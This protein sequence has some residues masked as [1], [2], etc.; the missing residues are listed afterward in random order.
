MRA[1]R[2]IAGNAG[3]ADNCGKCGQCGQCSNEH[4]AKATITLKRKMTEDRPKSLAT[5]QARPAYCDS[6]KCLKPRTGGPG[7]PGPICR[8]E[9][10][11]LFGDLDDLQSRYE[12]AE[13]MVNE[14]QKQEEALQ[15]QINTV[16]ERKVHTHTHKHT[17]THTDTHTLQVAMRHIMQ[18]CKDL[19]CAIQRAKEQHSVSSPSN[20]A[21]AS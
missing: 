5:W 21:S 17:H 13:K 15:R 8:C 1:M 11:G 7:T 9:E 4:L 14:Y 3:N 10:K 2:T 19:I 20:P 16:V 12:Q 18:H 6:C